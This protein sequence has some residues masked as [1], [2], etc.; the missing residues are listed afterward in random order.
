MGLIDHL[1]HYSNKQ[2]SGFL[3]LVDGRRIQIGSLTVINETHIQT[4]RA[5]SGSTMDI[6]LARIRSWLPDREPA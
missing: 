4:V 5:D 1:R 2:V 6:Q 3:M